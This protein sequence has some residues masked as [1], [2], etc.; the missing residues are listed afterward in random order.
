MI[1][2]DIAQARARG[3]LQHAAKLKLVLK[4]FVET[5][6]AHKPSG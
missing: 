2:D 5:H 6:P 4:H 1:L 3:D